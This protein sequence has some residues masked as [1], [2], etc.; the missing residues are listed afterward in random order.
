MTDSSAG[1]MEMSRFPLVA[2][3]NSPSINSWWGKLKQQTGI[4]YQKKSNLKGQ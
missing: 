2:L 1:L 4:S 3:Q